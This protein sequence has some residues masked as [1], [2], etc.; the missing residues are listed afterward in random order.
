MNLQKQ[1]AQDKIVDVN[2]RLGNNFI[3][4]MQ[5]TTKMVFDTLPIVAGQNNYSFFRDTNQRGFPFCNV[6][7][8]SLQVAETLSCQRISLSVV[9][10]TQDE[11]TLDFIYTVYTL[12]DAIIAFPGLSALNLA[13]LQLMIANDVTMRPIP[14]QHFLPAFNKTSTNENLSIFEFNTDQIIPPQLNFEYGLRTL[15][16]NPGEDILF[17]RLIVEGVGSQ[18]NGKT[19]F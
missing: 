9:E 14:I 16:L 6:Q 8:D 4:K 19:N 7:N 18:F 3:Q 2:N 1:R 13:T 11:P 10:R 17:L 12:E 5:G 15:P